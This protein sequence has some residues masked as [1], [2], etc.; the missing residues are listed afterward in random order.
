M[1]SGAERPR[2][3]IMAKLSLNLPDRMIEALEAD[4][5]GAGVSLPALLMAD[6][7]RYRALA[8]AAVPTLTDWQWDCLSHVMS[9]IEGHRILSGSDDLP[10][11]GSIITEIDTWADGAMDDDTLRAGELIQRVKSW[12]PLTVAGILMRL[13]RRG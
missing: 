7:I 9:G 3:H 5:D 10:G 2:T 12:P 1:E 13:R 6:L 8:D 4:A 11:A